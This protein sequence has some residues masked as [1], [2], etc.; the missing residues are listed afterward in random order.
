MGIMGNVLNKW[1]EA[2]LRLTGWSMRELARRAGLNQSYVSR[3]LSGRDNPGAK[4]Y[5]G[6]AK[7]FD[8][9]LSSIEIL[10]KEGIVPDDEEPLE[11]MSFGE[12]RAVLGQLTASQRIEL[13]KYAFRLAIGKD[14]DASGP[15][16]SGE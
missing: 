8:I 1:I 13:L 15:P 4:F 7:A 14:D 5:Q 2:K 11:D 12:W 6:V 9:P 10:D 3:V 16:S